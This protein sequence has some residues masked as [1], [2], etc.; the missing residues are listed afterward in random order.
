MLREIH[1]WRINVPELIPTIGLEV[2]CQLNTKTKMF[3]GCR[4]VHGAAVNSAVCPICLG[5][6]GALPVVND[7]AVRLAVRAGLA[8]GC[9]IHESSVFSRK[10]YFYPDLPKGYQISQFDRPICRGGRIHVDLDG[11]RRSYE[12]ERIHMEEDAG[13]LTHD[14][15][16]SLVDWNRGGTPLIEIVGKPD[17]HSAD[18]AV[19]WFK[20]MHRVMTAAGVTIGDLQKGHFRCD[21]NVSLAEEGAPLGTRVELKNINSFRFL[22]KAIRHEIQRQTKLLQAGDDVV[23]STRTWTGTETV[24]LRSKEDAADYRYFPEPDL[25]PVAV[26][27]SDRADARAKLDSI[28]LDVWLLDQDIQ[29]L[30]TFQAQYGLVEVDASALLA[31]P[32][33]LTLFRET[34]SRGSDAHEIVKWIRGPVARWRNESDGAPMMLTAMHLQELQ[35]LVDEGVITNSVGRDL[36]P[37]ICENG[38]SVTEMVASRGLARIRDTEKVAQVAQELVHKHADATEKYR[39]GDQRVLGFFMGQAMRSFGGTVDAQEMKKALMLAL[40][41]D[42]EGS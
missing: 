40:A 5:H 1:G 2:H 17:I 10:H 14:G 16:R 11:E 13:K 38:G 32:D 28:P 19:E 12:L 6:P 18:A 15:E 34:V 3:C 39:A 4:V 9:D 33:L 7:Q 29:A 30:E 24:A 35:Q 41:G 25:G 20:M 23:Q 26:L 27:A 21:A 42:A 37:E 36:V 8:L 22:A 31:A